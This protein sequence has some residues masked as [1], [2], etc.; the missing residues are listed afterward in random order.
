[1][2]RTYKFRSLKSDRATVEPGEYGATAEASLEEIP[3]PPPR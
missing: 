2:N 1:M 3:I